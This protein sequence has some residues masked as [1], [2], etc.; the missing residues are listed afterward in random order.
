MGINEELKEIRN[1]V[2]RIKQDI[3][4]INRVQ[5]LSSSAAILQDVRNTVRRS[6]IMVAVLYS[7]RDWVASADLAKTLEIDQTNLNKFLNPLLERGLLYRR[8][9]GKKVYFRR[10]DLLDLVNFEGVDEFKT[11]FESWNQSDN[12]QD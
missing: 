9:D 2:E 3:N 4:S 12:R 6:K 5:V 8:R 7:T 11:I 10:A 1:D